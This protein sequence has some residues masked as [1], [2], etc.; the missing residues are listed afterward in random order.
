MNGKWK[1]GAVL[2]AAAVLPLVGVGAAQAEPEAPADTVAR[3][4]AAAVPAG[5][6]CDLPPWHNDVPYLLPSPYS[7]GYGTSS[8]AMTQLRISDKNLATVTT[9]NSDVRVSLENEDGQ[10]CGPTG[11]HPVPGGYFAAIGFLNNTG[12]SVRTCLHHPT[13]GKICGKAKVE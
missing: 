11:V 7:F 6:D 4:A 12:H 1:M 10:V 8:V 3:A 9:E 5:S 13:G 2:A